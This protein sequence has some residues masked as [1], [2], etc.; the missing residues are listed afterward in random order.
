MIEMEMLVSL[1]PSIITR[2][3]CE[4]NYHTLHHRYVQLYVPIKKF[5][6]QETLMGNTLSYE[7]DFF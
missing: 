2:Y 7:K 6:N 4:L 5:K 1:I 3:I